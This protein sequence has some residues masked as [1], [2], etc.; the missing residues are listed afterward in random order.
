MP[1]PP[2]TT[3]G[4]VVPALS[5]SC[6]AF[7]LV[8]YT[9]ALRIPFTSV[10]TPIDIAYSGVQF[11]IVLLFASSLIAILPFL[12]PRAPSELHLLIV[13]SSG[14]LISSLAVLFF[15]MGVVDDLGID[16]SINY[17]SPL[18][19]RTVL[20][21]IEVNLYLFFNAVRIFI[22]IAIMLILI[23]VWR[24]VRYSLQMRGDP[25]QTIGPRSIRFLNICVIASAFILLLTPMEL[26]YLFGS[27]ELSKPDRNVFYGD[28]LKV[29]ECNNRVRVIY[30]GSNAMVLTCA[31]LKGRLLYI[32]DPSNVV[33][34]IDKP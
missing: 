26:G 6:G 28:G 18:Y 8:G 2:I 11:L 14:S 7:Y 30:R 29:P 1:E 24:F 12:T 15:V 16:S 27:S 22:P 10:V 20:G 5:L 21:D 17:P 34:L 31:G 9:A 23:S 33:L 3:V 25:S 4:L 32:H 19:Y 13:R